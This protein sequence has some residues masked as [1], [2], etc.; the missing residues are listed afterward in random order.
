MEVPVVSEEQ[1]TELDQ[2]VSRLEQVAQTSAESAKSL[3]VALGR[4]RPTARAAPATPP[5]G[6]DVGEPAQAA[7]D[8]GELAAT[9]DNGGLGKAERQILV[10]LAQHGPRTTTQV[11]LLTR[12]SHKSGASSTP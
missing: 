7:T 3:A 11:A 9:S 6:P 12:R 4:A 8:E 1:T 10:A 5:A 2:L